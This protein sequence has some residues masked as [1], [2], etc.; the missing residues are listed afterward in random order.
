M[1]RQMGDPPDGT[2]FRA[3]F[4]RELP[5]VVRALR[6][7]GVH[8]GDLPDVAQDL[9]ITVFDRLSEHDPST[10]VRRWLFAFCVR[11]AANYRRL[12][13]HRTSELDERA[14][15]DRGAQLEG[16]ARDLVVRALDGLEFDQ[17]VALVLHDLEGVTAPEIAAMTEVPLN[18]VY[19][20]IR[21]AREAFRAEIGKLGYTEGGAP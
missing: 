20:R 1:S 9:F 19:S 8:E 14:L 21:L 6:R 2:E 3:L 18:T 12:A 11:F 4:E 17:R 5:F 16:E 7:L 15:V 10:P 13:R